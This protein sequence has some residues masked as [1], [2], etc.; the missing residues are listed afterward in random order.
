M[1]RTKFTTNQAA[2]LKCVSNRVLKFFLN[3]EN[4]IVDLKQTLYLQINLLVTRCT[5]EL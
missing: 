2:Y 1:E 5:Y 3:L 4:V